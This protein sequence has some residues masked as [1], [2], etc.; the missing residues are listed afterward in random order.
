MTSSC[1][2]ISRHE[3]VHNTRLKNESILVPREFRYFFTIHCFIFTPIFPPAPYTNNN[4]ILERLHFDVKVALKFLSGTK[5][6]FLFII[7]GFNYKSLRKTG[8]TTELTR[9]TRFYKYVR[10]VIIWKPS[11]YLQ[12]DMRNSSGDHSKLR[13]N[14]CLDTLTTPSHFTT[15]K[16][17]EVKVEYLAPMVSTGNVLSSLLRQETGHPHYHF[18]WISWSLQVNTGIKPWTRQRQISFSSILHRFFDQFFNRQLTASE[19]GCVS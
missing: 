16:F 11:T 18:S 12:L 19:S 1:L 3:G 13:L 10:R 14:K 17:R 8:V 9:P 7:K 2:L 6:K 5:T 4:V 15:S